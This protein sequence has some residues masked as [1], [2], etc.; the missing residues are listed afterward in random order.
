M[1]KNILWH[2]IARNIDRNTQ[3]RAMQL[4]YPY[5]LCR[6]YVLPIKEQ[7]MRLFT[8]LLYNN[9]LKLRLVPSV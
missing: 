3:A 2:F 5:A 4:L 6:Y 1:I 7:G 8:L 9:S